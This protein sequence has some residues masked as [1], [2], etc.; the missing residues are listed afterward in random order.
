MPDAQHVPD[1]QQESDSIESAVLDLLTGP[2]GHRLWSVEEIGREVG[3][4]LKASDALAALHRAGLVHRTS[5]G[6]VFA[7]RAAIRYAELAGQVS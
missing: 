1:P 6:F 3:S 2:G 5:D 4:S 7:T